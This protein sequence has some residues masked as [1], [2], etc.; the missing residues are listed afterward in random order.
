MAIE[1]RAH[2][3][4]G[5]PPAMPSPAGGPRHPARLRLILLLIAL[6]VLGLVLVLG[7]RLVQGDR[8]LGEVKLRPYRAPDFTLT[9]F[10]GER[11]SLAGQRGKVVLVNFWA[12]WCV[13][14]KDEAPILESAWERY[15]S[16]GVVFVGV[17]IKDTPQDARGFLQ[18]Y[19][20]S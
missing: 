8:T 2:T 18:R 14:C 3:A 15:G 4:M 13:P 20:I 6:V 7:I 17:D 19:G 9:Q 10:D 12:S 16:R 11:F 1:I 5:T